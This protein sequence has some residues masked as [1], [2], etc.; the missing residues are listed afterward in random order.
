ML[1]KASSSDYLPSM[2][3]PETL[4]LDD[5]IFQ[6]VKFMAEG[7]IADNH[8]PAIDEIMAVGPD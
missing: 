1:S 5:E 7:M 6:S 4:L 8:Q 3:Y 2:L